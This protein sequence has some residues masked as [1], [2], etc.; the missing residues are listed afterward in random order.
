MRAALLAALLAL[1]AV[2]SAGPFHDVVKYG[3]RHRAPGTAAF[4]NVSHTI[5]LNPCL[6]NGCVV[7]PGNDDAKT[8]TS[9][10]PQSQATLTAWPHGQ[11][12]WNN[13]LQCVRDMYAPFDI[14]V[15]DVDPGN[16]DHFEVMVAG[17][18][19]AIGVPGAGGVAPFVPCDGAL[20]NNIISFVFAADISNQDFLCWA[21]AQESSHVFGLDHELNAKDPMTYLT[22]PI[23]KPGFQNE[24]SDCGEDTPRAC[25]CGGT[26]Q[27]SYQYL[28]DTFGPSN[29]EPATLAITSPKDGAWVKPGF[30]VRFES[31]SQLSV[32]TASLKVDGTQAQTIGQG[33]PHVFNTPATLTGGD[34]LVAVDAMDTGSRSMSS[35]I[36]VHVMAACSAS[37]PC[38]TGHCLG[39]Y[40]LPGASVD[41][42]LGATC[43]SN[44]DCV[45]ETCGLTGASGL[46]T[47][48]CDAG[49]KCP[50]GFA[51]VDAGGTNVCWPSDDDGGCSTNGSDV[52]AS[53]PLFGL[54][55]LVLIVRRRR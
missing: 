28:M 47:D 44:D 13:L 4:T 32:T 7:R 50:S 27:N 25:F 30:A 42:G 23:K 46:C 52:P 17:N 45:T 37:A 18:A 24:A 11:T 26:K 33:D 5:Y 43:D 55:L 9:S 41:G 8:D 51:C 29:L 22:P 6:P 34:H 38:E 35:S 15:T 31:M 19:N 40:C 12:A 1:P 49:N 21:A 16:A 53:L 2:A 20:E 10:I 3:A 39:G 14:Q 36:T 48:D 54:G